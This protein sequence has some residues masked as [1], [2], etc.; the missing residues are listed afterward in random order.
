MRRTAG[1]T[2]QATDLLAGT[3]VYGT[4]GTYTS[5]SDFSVDFESTVP[6]WN[7]FLL[8]TGT[9]NHWM[10]MTKEA[11]I[12]GHWS[13]ADREVLRSHTSSTP[14]NVQVRCC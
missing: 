8:A 7:E 6:G 9:C 11:L 4:P 13:P 1:N 5:S 14:Y 3:D 10:V 2:H 12:G